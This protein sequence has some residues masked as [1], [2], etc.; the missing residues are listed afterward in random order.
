MADETIA[1]VVASMR[2]RAEDGPARERAQG[3]F[4]VEVMS[5]SHL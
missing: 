5:F 3:V 4:G 2:G 1:D